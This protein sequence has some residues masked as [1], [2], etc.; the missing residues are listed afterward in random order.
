MGLLQS[1]QKVSQLPGKTVSAA[2]NDIHSQLDGLFQDFSRKNTFKGINPLNNPLSNP[3]SVGR[4]WGTA[5]ASNVADEQ[6]YTPQF[7]KTVM[8][9]NP[10]VGSSLEQGVGGKYT[11]ASNQISL[12]SQQLD[13]YTVTHEGLHAAYDTKSQRGKDAIDQLLELATTNQ[14]EGVSSNLK[15][16]IYNGISPDDVRDESHSYL[17]YYNQYG[18]D[19]KVTAYYKHYFSNPNFN[20]GGETAYKVGVASGIKKGRKAQFSDYK[21]Q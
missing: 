3:T 12:R 8:G 10:Y 4:V 16:T 20:K 17:P 15:N 14:R 21:D 5:V 18:E 7:R 6:G 2:K 1:L 9:A 13:P 11:P 19:P